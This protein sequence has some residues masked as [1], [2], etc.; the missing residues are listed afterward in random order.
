[1]NKG[2]CIR[3]KIT[4]LYTNVRLL[5][6]NYLIF[7]KKVSPFCKMNDDGKLSAMLPQCIDFSCV[8]NKETGNRN[9]C[10]PS[11]LCGRT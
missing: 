7:L 6:Y 8:D 3:R 1:M 5:M 2:E 4:K 11:I 9:L 10:A